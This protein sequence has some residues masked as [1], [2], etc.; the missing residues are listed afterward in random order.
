MS[1][2]QGLRDRKGVSCYIKKKGGVIWGVSSA[3][4]SRK[5]R[6]YHLPIR[7]SSFICIR[8]SMYLLFMWFCFCFCF[9]GSYRAAEVLIGWCLRGYPDNLE[10]ALPGLQ[11]LFL[12][13]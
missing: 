12:G 4:H 5:C 11:F 2:M 7:S 9:K 13:D 1:P 10:R 6:I 8:T 3:F